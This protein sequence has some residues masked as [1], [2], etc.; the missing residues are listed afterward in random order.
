MA[1][2]TTVEPILYAGLAELAD[3]RDLGSRA[4]RRKGSS[5]LSGTI[6]PLTRITT[7]LPPTLEPDLYG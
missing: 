6:K 7:K 3:T 4:A 5:P 2:L 1:P